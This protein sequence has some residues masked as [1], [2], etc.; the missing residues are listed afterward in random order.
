MNPGTATFTTPAPRLHRTWLLHLNIQTQLSASTPIRSI[1]LRDT[2][3][4]FCQQPSDF[5]C[6]YFLPRGLFQSFNSYTFALLQSSRLNRL[7]AQ[8]PGSAP[9]YL[10][11][12]RY[13]PMRLQLSLVLFLHLVLLLA[14][15]VCAAPS[16]TTHYESMVQ[17]ANVD[18]AVSDQQ[19]IT[20][21]THM[22]TYVQAS[23]LPMPF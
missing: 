10:H 22:D 8:E 21:I 3:L 12:H 5:L 11:T 1:G 6:D 14:H 13:Q 4:S 15:A 9:L 23:V 19:T 7:A 18:L 16:G 17:R 2:G 20:T